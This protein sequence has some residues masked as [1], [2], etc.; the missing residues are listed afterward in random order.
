MNDPLHYHAQAPAGKLEIKP[1]KPMRTAED[2]SLAYSPGV[3]KVSEA[4]HDNP[5]TVWDYTT[6]GNLV[7]VVS[8]GTAVLGLGD[9]G[10]AAALPVMEGKSALLKAFANVDSIPLCYDYADE[11]HVEA[12]VEA[13][14]PLEKTF[15]AINLEDVK[16]PYCFEIQKRLDEAMDIPVFH[17]DQDGTAIILV[18][19]LMN[20]LQIVGKKMDEIKICINGAGAA[21]IAFA[22]LLA[23]YGVQK[24]QIFMC[25]SRGLIVMGRESL[26]PHKEEFAQDLSMLDLP[27]KPGLADAMKGT[28]VFV[29]VSKG[30]IVSQD[31]VRSMAADAIL[32]AVANP[33]PEIMPDEAFAAGARIVGTGRS[34]FPNQ[35]NNVL[36]FPGIFRGALDA[37]AKSITQKMKLAAAEALAQI[38][39][40]P[41]EGEV[42]EALVEAYPDEAAKFTQTGP[43]EDYIIPKPFDKRV[44]PRVAEAVRKAAS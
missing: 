40:E 28:D 7:A 17:D 32:F 2:L 42:L 25:D 37:R 31:M 21:G 44:V 8:D 13:V 22:R 38:I 30:G 11:D 23:S 9:I 12:F 10:A 29:G 41:A 26:N 4:I 24:E 35:V 39:H 19:G 34:D 14:K 5:D 43:S 6:R 20:A 33:I 15:G 18:A 27:D 16:A 36:G 3:A 1:S